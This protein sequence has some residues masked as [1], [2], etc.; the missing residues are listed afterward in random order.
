MPADHPPTHPVED[1]IERAVA[2]ASDVIE[3]A[4]RFPER[5]Q[6]RWRWNGLSRRGERWFNVTATGVLLIFV[7]G[8]AWSLAEASSATFDDGGRRD[9][10]SL[11]TARI[12]AALSDPNAPTA[13]FLTDATLA[14]VDPGR[15]LSGA[16]RATVRDPGEPLDVGN[17]P[18]GADV[19]FTGS[20]RVASADAENGGTSGGASAAAG[21]A[22]AVTDP[23][24]VVAPERPGIWRLVL[25]A[26]SALRPV[27][28]FAVIT[29]RPLSARRD[30]RVGLYYIGSWPTERSPRRGYTTPSGF[31][32]VTRENQDTHV[33]DH[34]ELR[35][36]LT[37]GQEDVWPKYLVLDMQL[38]DKLELVLD[39]L[40]SRG[41]DVSGV[42]VM[43]GFRTP[44]YNATGGNTAGRASLSR[45][46][47]G[48]ASDVY[49]DSD[50]DGWMDDINRDGRVD[51]G[52]ARYL[53]AAAERVER[54][55]PTLIGG[56]GIYSAGPGHGPFVHIDT[57][58]YRARW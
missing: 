43:S 20:E 24:S 7:V 44:R 12:A 11:P 14:A 38:V 32:E 29:R 37:K 13:A 19:G 33:S 18:E 30:G 34:F 47:Y 8:W 40:Q 55:Y 17:V 48:D 35:D 27:T 6:S 41:V 4:L 50:G 22:A 57:R 21:T 23:D 10:L 28:D 39:D 16:L 53:A 49:I 15:G 56:I 26:G 42:R 25:R 52:D 9:G 5:R 54:K 58:G 36:F 46:M 2:E 51:T 45:H 31:I 1:A 3:L